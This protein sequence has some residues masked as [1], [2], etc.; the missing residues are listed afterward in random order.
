ML[1]LHR[2]SSH[3]HI[4]KD[5]S[6]GVGVLQGFSLVLDGGQCPIDLSQLFLI[7]LFS[8]QGQQSSCVQREMKPSELFSRQIPE[9]ANMVQFSNIPIKY[10]FRCH[11][12]GSHWV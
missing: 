7:A 2:F 8:L 3:A 9:F 6:V 11:C 5:F 10:S 1:V 12:G 4:L